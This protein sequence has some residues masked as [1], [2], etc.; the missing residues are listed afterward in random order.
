MAA[1]GCRAQLRR[2]QPA[3]VHRRRRARLTAAPARLYRRGPRAVEAATGGVDALHPPVEEPGP[4]PRRLVAVRPDMEGDGVD[5]RPAR[6]LRAR[7]GFAPA[8]RAAHAG[9]RRPESPAGAG[10]AGAAPAVRPVA[11]EPDET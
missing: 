5:R 7:S 10:R 3:V 8:A 6:E 1:A 2:R 4:L 11:A 9:R